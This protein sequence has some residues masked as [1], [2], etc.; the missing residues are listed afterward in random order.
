MLAA[1]RAATTSTRNTLREQHRQIEPGS[2]K[3]QSIGVS[4]FFGGAFAPAASSPSKPGNGAA[5]DSD[6]DFEV[7]EENEDELVCNLL[8]DATVSERP[9]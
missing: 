8:R 1:K 4:H 3:S 7:I 6:A 5:L 2:L 9:V